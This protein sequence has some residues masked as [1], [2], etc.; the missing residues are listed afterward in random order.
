MGGAK[1][2]AGY[3]IKEIWQLK[4]SLYRDCLTAIVLVNSEYIHVRQLV[5]F[6]SSSLAHCTALSSVQASFLACLQSC[7]AA[8]SVGSQ[9]QTH[10]A[11]LE[12]CRTSWPVVWT[13]HGC[14]LWC[15][16]PVECVSFLFHQCTMACILGR[17]NANIIRWLAATIPFE[18][19]VKISGFKFYFIR[20]D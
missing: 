19:A 9:L 15:L 20:M 3:L 7:R 8:L 1:N 17:E 12:Q 5:A 10:R 16:D 2:C 11:W 6:N 13:F 18:N 4:I 14:F